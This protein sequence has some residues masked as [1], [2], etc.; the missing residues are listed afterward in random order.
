MGRS[1]K[2]MFD[3]KRFGRSIGKIFVQIWVS[4]PLLSQGRVK[5]KSL[6]RQTSR[7]TLAK[8]MQPEI[9]NGPSG[10]SPSAHD[11]YIEMRKMQKKTFLGRRGFFM[12]GHPGGRQTQLKGPP[13][14][15]GSGEERRSAIKHHPRQNPTPDSTPSSFRPS[16]KAGVF[17]ILFSSLKATSQFSSW[18]KDVLLGLF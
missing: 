7:T 1:R 8:H 2:R 5:G 15:Q 18:A 9:R 4:S 13:A 6:E 11:I 17:Q 16:T 3:R 14:T 10:R 12:L